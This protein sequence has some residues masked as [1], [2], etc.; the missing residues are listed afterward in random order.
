MRTF[1]ILVGL[2]L[3]CW[4]IWRHARKADL[5]N[6]MRDQQAIDSWQG[7][8]Q[9]DRRTDYNASREPT[10]PELAAEEARQRPQEGRN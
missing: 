2:A 8:I 4:L 9:L 3:C 6:T 7:S 5:P 10:P 1:L